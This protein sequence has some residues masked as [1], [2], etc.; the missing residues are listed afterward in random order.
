LLLL[1]ILKEL[2]KE[3][4]ESLVINEEDGYTIQE[5]SDFHKDLPLFTDEAST[6]ALQDS[7]R[8]MFSE[9]YKLKGLLN[10]IRILEQIIITYFDYY[11]DRL[12]ESYLDSGSDY[13]NYY[14]INPYGYFGVEEQEYLEEYEVFEYDNSYEDEDEDDI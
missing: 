3:Y 12:P 10:K 13:V 6:K 2:I 4:E 11:H 9:Q 5:D 14:E 1:I 8:E 7:L